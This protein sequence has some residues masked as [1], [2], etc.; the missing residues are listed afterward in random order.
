MEEW[1]VV[2]LAGGWIGACLGASSVPFH[3]H[4]RFDDSRLVKSD[5]DL[6]KIQ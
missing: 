3:C 2:F 5:S 4:V 1:L 6:L